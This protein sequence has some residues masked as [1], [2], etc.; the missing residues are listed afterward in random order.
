M[1]SVVVPVLRSAVENWSSRRQ[2]V[3]P[4]QGPSSGERAVVGLEVAVGQS[5]DA[6]LGRLRREVG[7]IRVHDLAD[8]RLVGALVGPGESLELQVDVDAAD[9]RL[10]RID[11]R[12]GRQ[13]GLVAAG[14]RELALDVAAVVIERVDL[15]AVHAERREL[16]LVHAGEAG[17]LEDQL[18][19]DGQHERLDALAAHLGEVGLGG[20]GRGGAW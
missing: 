18:R 11:A 2:P 10:H 1:S 17:A 12:R 20:R 8:S 14:I 19:V 13:L 4:T 5:I 3:P 16:R 15:L 6:E 7:A 9:L